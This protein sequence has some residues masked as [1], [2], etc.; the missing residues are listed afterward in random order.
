MKSIFL[1]IDYNS[2]FAT[3][4]Q[5]ANPR[6]RGKPIGVTGG[7]RTERTVIG[8][9]S[10]EAKALGIK[11][12]MSIQEARRIYPQIILV[13]G[14]S[15]K[16][17]ACTKRFINILKD[18]SPY[19]EIF[20]ID[21]AFME[22]D[23][24]NWRVS[25]LREASELANQLN[26]DDGHRWEG[27]IR[28]AIAIKERI[29]KEIGDWL[30]VSI[31]VSYNKTLAKLAGSLY[32]PDGL[33][34]IADETAAMQILDQI[35]FDD[36]CGIGPRTKAHLFNMGITDF[37]T[38]RKVPLEILLASF[39]SYGKF[40]YNIARGENY[41]PLTPFYDKEEV[42]SVG[43]QH[44]LMK[45]TND[46]RELQ[47]ILL[48]MAEMVAKRLRDKKLVGRTVV[49]F[50]RYALGHSEGNDQTSETYRRQGF[51]DLE[52]S[53]AWSSGLKKWQQP[54]RP[55]FESAGMQT[56]IF[57]TDDGL[58]IFKAAWRSLQKLWDKESIRLLGISVSNV[59][60]KNEETLSLLA[61]VNRTEVITRAIDKVNDRFGDFVLKRGVLINSGSMKR[62]PNPFLSDR[63]FKI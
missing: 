23:A 8:A 30:R 7:D 26:M 52:I 5:Q 38:L 9:A 19:L 6:L 44:T 46:V 62:K 35:Q 14:D 43:H 53:G 16:Y 63:R 11:T 55:H 21:E 61:D 45:D 54:S 33:H 12:G 40:L 48:K 28:V 1:H 20:S 50:F 39:K 37:P 24:A 13:R 27:A 47:Q 57:P 10:I 32:K 36:I 49:C 3:V 31:G 29:H 60:P 25:P 4:E 56:T 22:L 34:V 15:D 17:L 58:E 2:Y 59:R 41:D 18:Y 51:I 42:K